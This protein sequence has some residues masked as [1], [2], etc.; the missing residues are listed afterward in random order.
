MNPRKIVTLLVIIV[1]FFTY[2]L[3]AQIATDTLLASQY[4]KKADSL[5]ADK[6]HNESIDFFQKALPI[7]KKAKA[8]EKV[9]SCYNKISKNQWRKRKF[10]VSLSNAKKA[11][12]ISDQ[13]LKKNNKEEAYVYDNIGRYYESNPDYDRAMIYYQKALEI[14]QKIFPEIHEGLG[15]SYL[16]IA[17]I[18]TYTAK[19]KEALKYNKKAL[20]IHLK[21]FGPEH[22]STAFT[23]NNMGVVYSRL[24][25][26]MKSI[27]CYKKKLAITIKNNGEDD[28]QVGYTYINIGATYFKLNQYDEALQYFERAVLICINK[29]SLFGLSVSYDNIGSVYEA[30]GKYDTALEYHKKG[31]DITLE[32]DGESHPNAASKYMNIGEIYY[33]R[34]DIKKT[35]YYYNKALTIYLANY[36]KNHNRIANTYIYIGDI[37]KDEKK[38]EIA[39]EYYNK[40]LKGYFNIFDKNNPEIANA[41]LNIANLC[42]DQLLYKK[43]MVFYEKALNIYQDLFKEQHTLNISIYNNIGDTYYQWGNFNNA[44]I[45][46]NKAILANTKNDD[47]KN[48]F[49][50]NQYYNHK[51]LLETFQGKAKTLQSQYL[52]NNSIQNLDQSNVLYKEADILINHIRQSFQNYQDKIAFAKQVKEIYA[53]AIQTQLLLF[54]NKQDQELLEQT[55]YYAEKSKANTLKELLAASNAK[56]FTGLPTDLVTL[57]KELRINRAFYQ[58]KV[59]EEQSEQP[60]DTAKI[61]RYENQLFDVNRRQDSLTDILEK[62]YPKYYQLKHKN[63]IVSVSELQEQLNGRTTVVEFFTSD[64]ITYAF[65]IAKN[66]IAVQELATADLTKKVEAFRDAITS[67]HVGDFKTSAH[68]LYQDLIAP[69]ANQFVGDELIIIPDGSLWHL[70][71]ELLLAQH[72]DSNNPADLSYLLHNYAISYANSANLLFTDNKDTQKSKKQEECL[73]FS[74]SDSTNVVDAKTMSLATLRGAG[75]DLPGTRKE[76]KA[77][78]EIID[79]QYYFGSEAIEANFKKNANQYNILHLALHGEID[80]ERPENSKLYFTKSKDTIEDNLLYSHE[81]FA[82]DIP[83]ELTVLSACNTGS[84]KIAKGEGIMSLGTA[85]QYA[86]TKSLLLTSWEVSDQTTPELMKYFYTNLKAGMNKS[87]ALQQ[88]KLQY[89]KTADINRTHPFYWGG[90]Y[91]VGDAA[92]ISFSDHTW[93]YWLLA[94]GMLG[95]S[96]LIL[97]WYRRRSQ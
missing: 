49:N 58:S 1:G 26:L 18:Y 85:F 3:N 71:F 6:K 31:L 64:S 78:S 7:Y 82:L 22:K 51:L 48:T 8:W 73:A 52:K 5:L 79:G 97:L 20:K 45:Y 17:K 12:K 30:K 11:L 43:A 53:D 23:Y 55:F 91:L 27:E 33:S 34:N 50:P 69:I 87:K 19:Y 68:Q 41:Y 21:I 46:F 13:H 47:S 42:N 80:N 14:R 60:K 40:A 2:S 44:V 28:I 94:L 39:H 24:W 16:N 92:P 9:A 86:G 37:Y 38:Y 67:K 54:K 88:A 65:T 10:N 77:I 15:L 72:D 95:V 76:I 63:D 29:E 57:E 61:A 35:L 70:N 56:N 93:L 25:D 36:G 75:D 74:F 81:L 83:A 90:F 84:G 32:I 89:L 4:F 66:E 59:T 96:F 62:N